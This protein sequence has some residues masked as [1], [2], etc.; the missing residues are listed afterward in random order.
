MPTE[1]F[2]RTPRLDGT[3]PE[4]KRAEILRYFHATWDRYESLFQLLANDLAY[5]RKPIS[6]RHPLIFYLGH[7]A[8]FFV[9]KLVLAGLVDQRI[10]PRLE[11]LFAVGVDEMSWDDLD[12]TH[13]DWPSLDQLWDY[14]RR[15]RATL[16]RVIRDTPLTLPIGWQ[17]PFWVVLMGIEH[18]RIHLETSS[19]LI[20]QQELD[21]V[22]PHPD[23]S[24]C[25][26]SGPAPENTLVEIP[27]GQV[28]LGRD[29]A[30]PW[31]GWDNE[32]GHHEAEVSAFRAARYLTSNGE[33]LAFVTA[34]GYSDDS[35][36]DEEGLGWRRFAQARHPTFWV[37]D[38]DAWRLRLLAEEV[39]MPWDWP[40][41]TNCHEARAFCRWKARET[42][43]PVRLPSEDEWQRLYDHAGLADVAMDAPATAN[44]HLDHWASSCPVDRFPHGDLFDVVGNVWQWCETPTYPFAGFTVHPVYDDF[45]TPT[46]DNRHNI[47]KGGSWISTGNEARHVSRYAFRRH[48][49][50]HAGFRY[51]VSAT[52]ATQPDSRYETDA[53][54]SQ[55]AEFHY[56]GE[57]FG[58][59]NFPRAVADIAIAAWTRHG[60]G[61]PAGRVLDLGCA[62]G[63]SS[64]ELARQF[65]R[66]EGIDFSVR[67]IQTG[68]QLA[69]TGIIRYTLP[70]EG[71]LVQYRERRLEDLGLAEVAHR[72]TFWQGD[73][74]NLKPVFSGYDLILAVNLIDRLYAPRRFLGEVQERLNPGG[75]L[76]LASPYTWLEEHTPREEWV[77]GFKKDG[78]SYTTLDG[79]QDILGAH[80]ERV[81][82]PVEVPFVIRETRR[83]FQHSLSELTV[84]QR[85]ERPG[86]DQAVVTPS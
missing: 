19:V 24:P 30:D 1:L 32:Y 28:Q 3:D 69:E 41:E 31:Y 6:L 10:N 34:G 79:I 78:E 8:T 46:F 52:P 83:K 61:L 45:T 85:R 75:L 77:G 26:V 5:T 38:G 71:E 55:Y 49:F 82:G 12:E 7:T 64:F 21:W 74:C 15:V 72:V 54:L 14:R 17:D 4:A 57:Y 59:P 23:W 81:E 40:V 25:P 47:I 27:A 63:R 33:F 70:D 37:A 39:S 66:V 29:F 58:V 22:R 67:F 36:W 60:N 84:W 50:Q 76:V 73:A 48:F 44:L 56:G 2:A 11:S 42:G 13:Y 9:N 86:L 65:A 80:F 53:L 18:E 16:D 20:R 68:V 62:T 35:L 43:L 51:I